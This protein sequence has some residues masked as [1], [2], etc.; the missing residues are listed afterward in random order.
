MIDGLTF[1]AETHVYRFRGEVVP[2]VTSILKPLSD[3]SFVSAGVMKAACDFGH[4]VHLACELWDKGTLD[5]DQLDPALVPY[6]AGWKQFS[7]DYEVEW[8]LIEEVVYHPGMRYAGTLDRYGRMKGKRGPADIKSSA[9]FYP[10]VGPQLAAYKEAMP[11]R[12]PF[13]IRMG[14]LLKADG[15]YV[16][17]EFTNRTDWPLFASLITVRNWCAAHNV[18]PKF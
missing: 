15:T 9:E 7:V 18:T 16:A 17:R 12:Y 1:D 6:L 11:T 2:G 5:E 14:V 3:F 13:D 4:A 10:S 8:E